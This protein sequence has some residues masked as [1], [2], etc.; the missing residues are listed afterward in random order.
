MTSLHDENINI[1]KTGGRMIIILRSL[2]IYFFSSEISGL[3]TKRIV[4][5]QTPHILTSNLRL[6]FAKGPS[7]RAPGIMG[8]FSI[9]Q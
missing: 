5:D 2:D 3:K 7:D 6:L 1:D 4:P 8:S 9:K